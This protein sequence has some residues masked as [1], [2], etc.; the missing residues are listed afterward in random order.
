MNPTTNN[1]VNRSGNT[2]DCSSGTY[3][4]LDG[5]SS[6]SNSRATSKSN[7]KGKNLKNTQPAA[8]NSATMNSAT[9]N[10]E[11]S[12]TAANM[13]IPRN[14][15]FSANATSHNPDGTT[16]S[17]PIQGPAPSA[18]SSINN[19][20]TTASSSV[21]RPPTCEPDSEDPAPSW[22]AYSTTG[23]RGN[24]ATSS[25][26]QRTP[27]T[28]A[29]RSQQTTTAGAPSRTGT[30]TPTSRGQQSTIP[31]LPQSLDRIE[32]TL[33]NRA[34][35]H[36]PFGTHT[37]VPPGL[38]PFTCPFGC[39]ARRSQVGNIPYYIPNQPYLWYNCPVVAPG[40]AQ[41]AQMPL[42]NYS[43]ASAHWGSGG[44]SYYMAGPPAAA[45]THAQVPC[46]VAEPVWYAPQVQQPQ[47][48]QLQYV[49]YYTPAQPV[50]YYTPVT[51]APAQPSQPWVAYM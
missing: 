47:P 29:T 31:T 13:S 30:A 37:S 36:G 28:S 51:A 50:H 17:I 3:Y 10:V 12:S 18:G 9:N 19:N 34:R 14:V 39:H 48:Q 5:E 42:P 43:N 6:S 1:H 2:T 25:G 44:P 21:Y 45:P 40:S 23:N 15:D 22:T 24:T 7:G 46:Y 8:M 27:A 16:T 41:T 33:R 4:T 20:T 49:S 11:N 26:T 38:N 35:Q 32:Q